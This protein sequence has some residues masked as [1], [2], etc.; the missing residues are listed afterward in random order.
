MVAAEGCAAIWWKLRGLHLR[1]AT[2]TGCT[3]MEWL[4]RAALHRVAAMGGTAMGWQLR[5]V[6]QRSLAAKGLHCS[7]GS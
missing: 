7:D 3:M 2:A 5:A 1:R 4:L 6:L